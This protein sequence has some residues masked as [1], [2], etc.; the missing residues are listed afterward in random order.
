MI[1][2]CP[3]CKTRMKPKPPAGTPEGAK[4]SIKCRCGTTLRFTMP[5]TDPRVKKIFDDLRR[6][7]EGLYGK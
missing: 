6:M 5:G 1:V 2:E 3:D 7:S 4:V